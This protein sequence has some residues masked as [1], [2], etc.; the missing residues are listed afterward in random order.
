M[1]E[2]KKKLKENIGNWQWRCADLEQEN[3][4]L[5]EK[6]AKLEFTI[7]DLQWEPTLESKLSARPN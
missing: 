5:K 4:E 6:I 1:K 2:E 3:R 7:R